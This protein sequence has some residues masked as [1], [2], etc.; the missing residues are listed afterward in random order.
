MSRPW[1]PPMRMT[2]QELTDNT[3]ALWQPRTT[4]ELSGEDAREIAENLVG[5]FKVLSEWEAT[6]RS[7][8]RA[9]VAGGPSDG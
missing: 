9:S 8:Q 5:F 6:D 1:Q 4:R 7:H 2:R 3:I